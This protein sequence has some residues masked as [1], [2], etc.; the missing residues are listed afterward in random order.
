MI[1]DARSAAESV[2]AV[3][4][5]FEVFDPALRLCA[6]ILNQTGSE[7]HV[8]LI[9]DAMAAA[10]ATGFLGA[11]PEMPPLPCRSGISVCIWVK[12]Q[13]AV[14]GAELISWPRLSKTISTSTP[15]AAQPRRARRC[16][17]R[18][19][20]SQAG[21]KAAPGGARDAAF[22]STRKILIFWSVPVLIRSSSVRCPTLPCRRWRRR[23]HRR[24]IPR[25]ARGRLSANSGMRYRRS[26]VGSGWRG[27]YCECGGL[28]YMSR[29]LAGTDGRVYPMVDVFPLR[30][31]MKDV[32]TVGYRRVSPACGIVFSAGRGEVLHGHE[33]HLLEIGAEAVTKVHASL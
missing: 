1:V 5:G 2:A 17:H 19:I 8:R 32:S 28:M 25:T 6:I 12:K 21:E 30:M 14:G 22:A 4:K 10:C 23:L 20:R 9:R 3:I 31:V 11:F 26:A 13:P 24:R 16:R 27:M 29:D 18:K 7:R 15:A 33:F